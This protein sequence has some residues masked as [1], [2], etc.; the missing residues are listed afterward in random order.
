MSFSEVVRVGPSADS[1]CVCIKRGREISPSHSGPREDRSKVA[2]C[3][4]ERSHQKQ[5]PLDL[6][7]DLPASRTVGNSC[8]LFRSRQVCGVWLRQPELTQLH[9]ASTGQPN[10]DKD[11]FPIHQ[12]SLSTYCVTNA[13]QGIDKDQIPA[14]QSCHS[15]GDHTHR[16]GHIKTEILLLRRL[17]KGE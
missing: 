7:L 17:E 11:H 16:H 13:V 4:P 5:N 10:P 12:D 9:S 2:I 15:G 8:L 6:I 3:K 14:L 1:T